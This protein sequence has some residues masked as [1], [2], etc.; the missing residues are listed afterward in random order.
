MSGPFDRRDQEKASTCSPD[1]LDHTYDDCAEGGVAADRDERS[2]HRPIPRGRTGDASRQARFGAA[3]C[4]V[5]PPRTDLG[6]AAT[7]ARGPVQRVRSRLGMGRRRAVDYAGNLYDDLYQSNA[8][9]GG[10]GAWQHVELCTLDLCRPYRL[11]PVR[12]TLLP[13]PM[14]MHEHA[15]FL[16]NLDLSERDPRLDSG[17]SRA[18]LCRHQFS[19]PPCLRTCPEWVTTTFYSATAVHRGAAGHVSPRDGVVPGGDRG[20]YS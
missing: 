16:K 15:W 2:A 8:V 1:G 19:R 14:L 12:R 4:R 9:A 20:I 18:E 17:I 7:G 3:E 13:S 10:L 5:A 6:G 11:R